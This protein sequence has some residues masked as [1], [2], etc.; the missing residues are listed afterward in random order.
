MAG[1]LPSHRPD[2]ER[3]GLPDNWML[4]KGNTLMRF[5]LFPNIN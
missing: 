4:W 5:P 3:R 1:R 2:G